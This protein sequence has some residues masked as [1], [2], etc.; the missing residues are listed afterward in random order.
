MIPSSCQANQAVRI[1][2]RRWTPTLERQVLAVIREFRT[3]RCEW[4]PAGVVVR[5]LGLPARHALQTAL[6]RQLAIPREPAC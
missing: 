6:E 2:V 3:A 4:D 5:G 1:C